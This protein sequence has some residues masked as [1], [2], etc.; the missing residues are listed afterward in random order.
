MAWHGMAFPFSLQGEEEAGGWVG[1]GNHHRE[2]TSRGVPERVEGEGGANGGWSCLLGR[3]SRCLWMDGWMDGMSFR[4]SPLIMP[5]RHQFGLVYWRTRKMLSCTPRLGP[6]PAGQ[7]G[8]F[9]GQGVPGRRPS[10]A[11]LS[12]VCVTGSLD[13]GRAGRMVGILILLAQE[14]ARCE[15]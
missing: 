8:M 12:R 4:S 14:G 11:A 3:L 2:R 9:R 1:P 10:H 5:S 13:Q 15:A 7:F 6:R